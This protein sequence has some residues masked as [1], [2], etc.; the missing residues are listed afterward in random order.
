M[1]ERLTLWGEYRRNHTP[2]LKTDAKQVERV[3][4]ALDLFDQLLLLNRF[5]EPVRFRR[6]ADW[7]IAEMEEEVVQ[8]VLN[9]LTLPPT[10]KPAVM[11]LLHT[12]LSHAEIAL[13]AKCSREYVWQCAKAT[14]QTKRQATPGI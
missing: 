13:R 11:E 8:D 14:Q 5:V 1:I 7:Q 6:L 10:G 9:R 12:G 2:A 4:K 3:F